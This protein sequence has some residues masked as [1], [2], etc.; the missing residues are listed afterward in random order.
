MLLGIVSKRRILFRSTGDGKKGVMFELTRVSKGGLRLKGVTWTDP[1]P[2]R[3]Y[4]SKTGTVWLECVLCIE[5]ALQTSGPMGRA[6][7]VKQLEEDGVSNYTI[8]SLLT[9]NRKSSRR[10]RTVRM[11][12]TPQRLNTMKWTPILRSWVNP[13]WNGGRHPICTL[14]PQ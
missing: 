3:P 5:R 10:K 2:G 9:G 1:R 4:A 14:W 11:N 7:V 12:G 8:K 6:A 13:S